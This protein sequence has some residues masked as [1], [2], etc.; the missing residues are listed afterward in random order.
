MPCPAPWFAEFSSL[1][2]AAEV[3]K[4]PVPEVDKYGAIWKLKALAYSKVMEEA[5]PGLERIAKARA[6][7][8]SDSEQLMRNAKYN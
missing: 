2:T 3:L 1:I 6:K 8:Q 5:K 4:C 7:D